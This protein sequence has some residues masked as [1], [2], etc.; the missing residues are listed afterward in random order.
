MASGKF[1]RVLRIFILLAILIGVGMG[2]WT[3]KLRTT[4]WDQ[5]LW[6]VV[7]PINGDGSEASSKYIDSL[8]KE[9]F[10]PI[11]D[12]MKQEA[13]SY[14]LALSKPIIMKLSP[15]VNEL[16][17]EPPQDRNISKVMWW[18][19][20]LRFWAYRVD[21]YDGP[22]G[23]IRMFVLYYDPATHKQLEESLGLQKGLICVAKA[24][25]NWKMEEKNNV[26]L[27][28]ELLHTVGA[29]DKYN[30]STGQ[31]IYPEGYAEPDKKPLHPQEEAEIMGGRI[32]L[33]E[34]EA[35]MPESLDYTVIGRKTAWE[36]NWID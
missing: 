7:Y 29:T 22:A 16:P 12:F 27:A 26:V 13:E 32:P 33:S 21:T 24:F 14:E 8:Q 25:A 9:T 36:I 11:E 10:K 17:P 35:E 4:S 34:I 5:P 1:F 28:H 19:L 6:V 20:K 15:S 18:S 23:D 30:L 3:T 2:T 31:P